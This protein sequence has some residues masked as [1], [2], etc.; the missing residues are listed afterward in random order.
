M[1]F[2]HQ[3]INM[4]F[5]SRPMR[6]LLVLYCATVL[7]VAATQLGMAEAFGVHPKPSG[8]TSTNSGRLPITSLPLMTPNSNNSNNNNNNNNKIDDGT[9]TDRSSLAT[10]RPTKSK[11]SMNANA[12]T[13]LAAKKGKNGGEEDNDNDNNNGSFWDSV[14]DDKSK[15]GLIFTALLCTWHFWI[16][17]AIR[18]FILE[19]KR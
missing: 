11:T 13:A 3:S 18:P 15:P 16:G 9:A 14:I 17:P 7:L 19:L 10:E 6:S 8:T 12:S 5:A 2:F 1:L 4:A